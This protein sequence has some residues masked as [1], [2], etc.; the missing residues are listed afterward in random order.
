MLINKRKLLELARHHIFP[1]E[2]L[3][4]NLNP[5]DPE[6]KETLINNLA[7]ITFIH[8]DINSEIEDK[9][10]SEYLPDFIESAKKHFIPTD[11]N[12]WKI[13]QYTTFLEYRVNEIYSKGKELFSEIFE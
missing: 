11:Q 8:K 9:S 10:P 4:Q 12:L 2:F 6:L 7:N 13:E 3:E 5:E 1:K